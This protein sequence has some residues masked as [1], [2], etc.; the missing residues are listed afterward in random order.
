MSENSKGLSDVDSLQAKEIS[1][2]RS[3]LSILKRERIQLE[4]QKK[5]YEID[6]NFL[7]F[8]QQ[9]D[10]EALLEFFPNANIKRI[11]EIEGFHK[12][13][14]TVLTKEFKQSRK[15]IIDMINSI[16]SNIA[17]LEEKITSVSNIPNVSQAVLT[18]Y[19][20]LQNDIE[21]LKEANNNF[22]KLNKL[23]NRSTK[24]SNSFNILLKDVLSEVEKQINKKMKELNDIIYDGTKTAP[25][26]IIEKHNS[27]SFYTPNDSGTGAQYKGLVIFDI[28][29]LALTDIPLVVHDSLLLKQIEDEAIEKIIE[30]YTSL[31][32]Q[33]FIS[34]DKI[35]SYPESTQEILNKTKVLELYPGGGELF[36]YSW[37]KT[38]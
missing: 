3:E 23:K 5:S 2:L 24:L 20:D 37:N 8:T 21:Q 10:F 16:S 30:I 4:S 9:R 11:E 18:Q 34:L 26:L 27:Y 36:G 29:M 1:E 33:V 7:K 17:I 22:L 6:S 28:A 35:S 12:Q 19:A 25:E 13:V 14:R 38:N 32:K 15:N 31:D